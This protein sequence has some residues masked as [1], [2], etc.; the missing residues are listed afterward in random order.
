MQTGANGED[1]TTVLP[2]NLRATVMLLGCELHYAAL[3]DLQSLATSWQ[4][5]VL[6]LCAKEIFHDL[7]A[8]SVASG[9]AHGR[10]LVVDFV[11]S[12]YLWLGS[13]WVRCNV[14][15]VRG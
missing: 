5:V 12:L 9:K 6:K 1:G 15:G 13:V 4:L 10:G 7:D 11:Q 2:S 3:A 14:L 8:I